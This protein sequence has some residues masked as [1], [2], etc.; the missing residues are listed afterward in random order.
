MKTLDKQK[1]NVLTLCG[2]AM[3]SLLLWGCGGTIPTAESFERSDYYTRG[4]GQY[5]GDPKEDFSPSLAPDPSTSV[6][7]PGCDR[8]LP[9]PVMTI[10]WWRSWRQTAS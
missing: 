8:L 10:T 5:P 7:L 6:T 9:L 2:A 3:A 4:I 1:K